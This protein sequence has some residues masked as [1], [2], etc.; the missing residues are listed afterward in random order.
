MF[1][2]NTIMVQGIWILQPL[3]AILIHKVNQDS[4]KEVIW[5]I[6]V[7]DQ[8]YLEPTVLMLCNEHKEHC[9]D[10]R[11]LI[12][13]PFSTVKINGKLQQPHK[14]KAIKNSGPVGVKHCVI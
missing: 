13:L 9:L 3:L 6:R 14:D 11:E 1:L 5:L 10:P 8:D 7:V 4:E 2:P 12:V